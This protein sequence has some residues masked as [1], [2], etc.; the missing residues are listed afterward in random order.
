MRDRLS[1]S[2][3][4]LLKLQRQ[5]KIFMGVDELDERFIRLMD[6]SR[7][8]PGEARRGEAS[9]RQLCEELPDAERR[10]YI[11]IIII[12]MTMPVVP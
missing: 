11:L 2:I 7:C 10:L 3:E 9:R 1:G 8:G 12:I 4:G 5:T 6:N